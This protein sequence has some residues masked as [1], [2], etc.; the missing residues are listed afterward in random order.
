MN[1]AKGR[2]EYAKSRLAQSQANNTKAQRDLARYKE[3]VDKDED[4]KQQ[5][6]AAIG[7]G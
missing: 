6:D 1:A 3:L 2:L 4:G 5:Y 7:T